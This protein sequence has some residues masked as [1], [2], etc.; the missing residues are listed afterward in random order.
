MAKILRPALFILLLVALGGIAHGLNYMYF[1]NQELTRF[2]DRVKF[3]HGD[4]LCGPVRSNSE[5]AIMQDP[6]FCDLVITTSADFWRGSG[7][8]PQW[9]DDFAAIYN[10]PPLDMPNQAT[11]IRSLAMDQGHF[12][13]AGDSMKA[14]VQVLTD[15]L[16]I[17]WEV[18]G[19]P[20]DTSNYGEHFL[21][22]SAVVFFQC[23][24]MHL[25]G[26]VSGKLIIGASSTILLEDNLVYV[27]A[28]AHGFA[29]A[30]HPEKLAVVSEGDIKIQNTWANG[31]ENSHRRGSNQH[32]MDSTSIV[33]D[34]FYV[35]LGESFTFE[36]QNDPDSGYVC[37]PCGCNPGG[38][39]GG[40]DDRGTVYLFGGIMQMRRG[41]MHR[42]SCTSTGYLKSFHYDNDLRYWHLPVFDA[43]ENEISPRTL[44]FGAVMVG[45]L[46]VDTM[47][48]RNQYVPIRF[49]SL[50]VPSPF[51]VTT[52]HDSLMWEQV[53]PVRFAPTAAGVVVDTLRFYSDYYR[54]WFTLPVRGQGVT[55]SGADSPSA[56]LAKAFSLSA[57]PNPFNAQTQ[58]RYS[59]PQIGAVSMVL[60][61][62]AGRTVRVLVNGHHT[63]GGHTVAVD[64]AALP[65]GLYFIRLEAAGQM[66]TQK[67]LL[68][69]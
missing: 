47:R 25:F 64:G 62:V 68:L 55:A 27:S 23:S 35:A 52:E 28:D 45:Q 17:W 42:S 1:T 39:G 38:G 36:Q 61:D 37:I 60:Y 65:T 10:A 8:N 21:P 57:Y 20:F 40:P 15:R 30:G 58:I 13:F 18:R 51:F 6:Y 34:G 2:N 22:D 14:R 49:D 11:Q 26:L 31:R 12:F 41:Y 53:V 54:Q 69:K 67:V 48:M 4:T 16:R 33:L 56:P 50:R 59:V 29:P 7:Y 19:L 66:V 24:E 5:I 43:V 32:N 63:A 44:D 46:A 9:L 3:W